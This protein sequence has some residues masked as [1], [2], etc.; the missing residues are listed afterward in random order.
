MNPARVAWA[1]DLDCFHTPPHSLSSQH[2]LTP[3]QV[4][5]GLLLIC[6]VTLLYETSC[7]F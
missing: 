7:I 2:V 5:L 6:F 3:S 4:S 1:L